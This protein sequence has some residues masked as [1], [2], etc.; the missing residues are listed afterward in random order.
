MIHSTL[1]LPLRELELFCQRHGS[2][3]LA[4]FGSA[5]RDDFAPDSDILVEFEPGTRV[6]LSFFAIQQE[7]SEM[8]GRS[9]DLNTSGA[10]SSAFGKLC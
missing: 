3:R 5:P 2:G 4:L 8:L 1:D 9:I 10:L 7:L 6:G